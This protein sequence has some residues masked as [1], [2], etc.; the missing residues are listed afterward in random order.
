MAT[1]NDQP[2]ADVLAPA[3]GLS[4]DDW[5]NGRNTTPPNQADLDRWWLD[6]V[7]GVA[8]DSRD[9]MASNIALEGKA[10]DQFREGSAGG[11]GES[12]TTTTPPSN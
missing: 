12:E 8:T 9:A 3:V 4:F 7:R 10:I 2:P 5:K 1:V 6:L 11:F